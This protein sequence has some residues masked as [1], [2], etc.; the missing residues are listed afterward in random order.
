MGS[1]RR[2]ADRRQQQLGVNY[3]SFNSFGYRV[4]GK[5]LS[6]GS[7]A[8]ALTLYVT[9]EMLK[10]GNDFNSVWAVRKE[11]RPW[12][13]AQISYTP[14]NA[15]YNAAAQRTGLIELPAGIVGSNVFMEKQIDGQTYL[16]LPMAAASA[17]FVRGNRIFISAKDML[18]GAFSCIWQEQSSTPLSRLAWRRIAT[19]FMRRVRMGAVFSRLFL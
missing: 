11:P 15:A 1:A 18:T 10:Y 9:V 13:G 19:M 6:V 3:F 12:V 16:V 4:S 2:G 5:T 17:T 8:E 7:T 14:G